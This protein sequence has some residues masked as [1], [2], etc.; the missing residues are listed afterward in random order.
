MVIEALQ[1]VDVMAGRSIVSWVNGN[2]GSARLDLSDMPPAME[3]FTLEGT[4]T[5]Q[6]GDWMIQGVK[7]EFYPCKPD[8]FSETYE[9]E[10]PTPPPRRPETKKTL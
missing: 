10:I 4:H 8:V 9:P 6:L 3:V 7:G 5:A 1:F 2:N